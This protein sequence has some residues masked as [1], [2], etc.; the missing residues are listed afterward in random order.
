MRIA[1]RWKDYELIDASGSQR[2]ERWKD[3]ILIRPD[4]Q[5]IWDTEKRHPL[6]KQAHAMYHRSNTGGGSWEVFKK[7]PDRWQIN[8]GNLKFNIKPMGF[9]HTGVFP[10]QGVNWDFAAEKIRKSGL[11]E[12]K[13]LN[14]FGYTGCATLSCMAA[15]AT[16]C[17]V[18]ASKGMGCSGLRKTPFQVELKSFR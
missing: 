15:G 12:F 14:L 17:H 16:V 10:E 2:L 5:V 11:K 9:K 6:W 13:V 7:M 1:D 8:Y 18:D 3:I 4:P